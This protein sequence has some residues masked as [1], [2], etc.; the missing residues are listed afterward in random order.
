MR[1][2]S[3]E[4]KQGKQKKTEYLDIASWQMVNKKSSKDVY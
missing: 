2:S 4:K 3:K 1:I